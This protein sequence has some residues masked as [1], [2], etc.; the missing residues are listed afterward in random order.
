MATLSTQARDRLDAIRGY[1]AGQGSPINAIRFTEALLAEAYARA[2]VIGAFAV[3]YTS[4]ATGYAFR[5]LPYRNH[6]IVY[7]VVAE[8]VIAV[9]FYH[10]A[11]SQA[12]MEEDL[13]N[14]RP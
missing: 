4:P 3:F 7:C 1:I 2:G 5:Q 6:L 12:A 10:G 14:F 8:R 13:L 9:D 11:R